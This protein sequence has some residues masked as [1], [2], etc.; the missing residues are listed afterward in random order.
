MF[1][2]K[3]SLKQDNDYV[4]KHYIKIVGLKFIDMDKKEVK[5]WY[6][7]KGKRELGFKLDFLDDEKWIS[8]DNQLLY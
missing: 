7:N 4:Y 1:K 6:N 2:I 8:N 5:Q 3:S